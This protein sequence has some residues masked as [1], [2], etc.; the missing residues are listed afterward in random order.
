VIEQL[1]RPPGSSQPGTDRIAIAVPAEG[2]T[3]IL[4]SYNAA[5]GEAF[6]L[7]TAEGHLVGDYLVLDERP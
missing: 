6:S 1:D 4:K 5:T 7:F 2:Y 3:L